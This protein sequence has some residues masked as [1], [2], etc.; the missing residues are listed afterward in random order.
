MRLVENSPTIVDGASAIVPAPMPT[1]I[2]E[3][4]RKERFS[5]YIQHWMQ[6][7]NQRTPK[8]VQDRSRKVGPGISDAL[9][10]KF[11]NCE[12]DDCNVSSIAGLADGL[13]RPPDEVFMAFL[14]KVSPADLREYKESDVAHMWQLCKALPGAERK[15]YTRMFKMVY[16][17]MVRLI[18][19]L[20]PE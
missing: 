3:T 19:L 5:A 16:A 7:N 20:K 14:G 17:D 4:E 18:D 12:K 13:T 8:E 10:A 1:P 9:I 11:L 15:V 2:D 6:E